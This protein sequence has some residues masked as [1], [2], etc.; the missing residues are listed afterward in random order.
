M[1]EVLLVPPRCSIPMQTQ[2]ISDNKSRLPPTLVTMPLSGSTIRNGHSNL[3]VFS[4]VNQN[5][6]FEFD[7][8]LKSGEVCKRTRK[9][10]VC[11]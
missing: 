1:A 4:P 10:K 7:R 8:V 6:S 11:D 3:D 9:T 5:G 2:N